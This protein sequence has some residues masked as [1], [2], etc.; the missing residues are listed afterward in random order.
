[1]NEVLPSENISHCS[2]FKHSTDN[3]IARDDYTSFREI[4][5]SYTRR[6]LIRLADG[7]LKGLMKFSLNLLTSFNITY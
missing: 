4:I 6:D 1:M 2:F 7:L 3:I 5:D